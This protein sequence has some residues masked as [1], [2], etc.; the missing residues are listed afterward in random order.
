M[1][2]KD[3]AHWC[4]LLQSLAYSPARTERREACPNLA[5]GLGRQT[6]KTSP[7]CNQ[8]ANLNGVQRCFVAPL[9]S[10]KSCGSRAREFDI[11]PSRFSRQLNSYN[12]QPLNYHPCFLAIWIRGRD[13]PTMHGSP[14][15]KE[16]AVGVYRAL[17]WCQSQI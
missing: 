13:G 14:E 1:L 5:K 15:P 4:C 3:T 9:R 11:S 2:S 10:N 6:I 16:R 7:V 8:Q 17:R 12:P